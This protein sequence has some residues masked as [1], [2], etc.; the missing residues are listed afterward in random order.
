MRRSI[1]AGGVTR[2]KAVVTVSAEIGGTART[3][4]CRGQA[5][6]AG[7]VLVEIDTSTLLRASPP[8]AEIDAATT[9]LDSAM[10]QSRGTYAEQR[11]CRGQASM[12]PEQRLD[13]AEAGFAEISARLSNWPS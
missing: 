13:I 8:K 10:A 6:E 9:A 7:A 4:A 3:P 12:S 5:V 2:P 1:R 11:R